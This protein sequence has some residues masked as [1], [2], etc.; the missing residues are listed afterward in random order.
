M[1]HNLLEKAPELDN[2]LSTLDK[3]I[4]DLSVDERATV[5]EELRQ[6][7]DAMIAAEEE[8]GASPSIAVDA[9]LEKF[10]NAKELG[11]RL[12][13]ESEQ[14]LVPASLRNVLAV[15]VVALLAQATLLGVAGEWLGPAG[16]VAAMAILGLGVGMYAEKRRP[17]FALT[18]AM[19]LFVVGGYVCPLLL[20][21]L[22]FDSATSVPHWVN[23]LA[24]GI[25][26]LLSDSIFT[27]L[28]LVIGVCFATARRTKRWQ[29]LDNSQMNTL[30]RRVWALRHGA[31]P[32]D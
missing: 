8:L 4:K 10:G 18:G 3:E 24:S 21:G 12:R 32:R 27:V 22:Y 29:M 31:P 14:N 20:M 9:A 6:H 16:R 30:P 13:V 11:R 28:F 5:R 23:T 26:D 2:Y 7:L 17:D 25:R 19:M 1:S 15:F